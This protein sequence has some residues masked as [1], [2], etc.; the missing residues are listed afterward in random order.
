[1]V[2]SFT[3]SVG[4]INYRVHPTHKKAMNRKFW[5]YGKVV[6]IPEL[7]TRKALQRQHLYWALK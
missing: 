3:F 5:N 1:M 4:M 6:I 7:E 2:S